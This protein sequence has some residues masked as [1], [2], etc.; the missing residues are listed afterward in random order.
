MKQGIIFDL[1]GTLV[2]SLNGIAS[3]LNFALSEMGFSAHSKSA[4][5]RFIGNGS[6][7]LAKRASPPDTSDEEINQVESIF[8]AYYDIHWAEGTVPYQGVSELLVKLKENG[9]ALAVLSNKPHPFTQ[10]IVEQLFPEITFDAVV[11]QRPGIP[12]KPDPAGAWEVIKILGLPLEDCLLVGDSTVDQETAKHAGIR[13]I[14]VTWGYHD[15]EALERCSDTVL[16]DDIP[17]LLDEIG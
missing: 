3:S 6:W 10:K 15:R 16:V 12:H 8:K 2:D 11:G 9:N 13:S 7:I 14:S 4:V 17:S 5:R 1:D